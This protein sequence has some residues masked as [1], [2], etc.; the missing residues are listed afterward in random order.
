DLT[1]VVQRPERLDEL[2]VTQVEQHLGNEPAVEQVQDG[3]LDPAGVVVDR[4]PSTQ[5]H[6]VDRDVLAVDGRKAQEIPG[7]VDEGVHRVGVPLG[8]VAAA[9]GE[10]PFG[11][12][13]WPRRSGSRTGNWSSG[14]GT[15]PSTGQ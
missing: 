10:M 9:S 11:A 13:S 5:L 6:R 7:R 15:S 1:L 8:R 14:T 4:R 12:R 3:V 2:D